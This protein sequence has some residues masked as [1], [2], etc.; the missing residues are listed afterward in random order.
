MTFIVSVPAAGAACSATAPSMLGLFLAGRQLSDA[1]HGQLL[2]AVSRRDNLGERGEDGV[3]S[4]AELDHALGNLNIQVWGQYW[5]SLYGRRLHEVLERLDSK[6]PGPVTRYYDRWD[7]SQING[8]VANVTR[9]ADAVD[10]LLA[11]TRGLSH[12]QSVAIQQHLG[13][14]RKEVEGCTSEQ[15]PLS[16][17]PPPR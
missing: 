16:N 6:P 11:R 17:Y 1:V 2:D 5:V 13:R 15:D 12:E 14:I 10:A 3:K 7:G 4:L 8:S 9:D